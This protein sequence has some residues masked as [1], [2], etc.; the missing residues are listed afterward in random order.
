M[1]ER[2][3]LPEMTALFTDKARFQAF[4]EVEVAAA[5]ALGDFGVIPK[6]AAAAIARDARIDIARIH[7]LEKATKHDVVA[8]TR[9][10]SE[11]LGDHAKWLHYGLTST[12]VVDTALAMVLRQA[13][14]IIKK[15]A[16][17]YQQTLKTLALTHRQTPCVGRT[18]GIHAEVTS[19]GLKFARFYDAFTRQLARFDATVSAMSVGKVSGAVGTYAHASPD[20]E[21]HVCNQLGLTPA[22][23]SSQVLDRDRHADLLHSLAMMGTELERVALEI[24]H[25]QRTEINEVSERFA[26]GQKGSSAM[27]HKQNPIA[28]ENITGCARLMRG[29]ASMARE[30]IALWHERDISHSSVERVAL[31]D[32]FMV[33]DYMLDRFAGVL[34]TLVV[35]EKRMRDNIDITRGGIFTQRVLHAMI[36]AGMDRNKA[37][38]T[39]QKTAFDAHEQGMHL[40]EALHQNDMV[41]A[42]LSKESIDACFDVMWFLRHVD[43]IYDRVFTEGWR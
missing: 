1:I 9:A 26:T 41:L 33:L 39:V 22:T 27:P 32:A 2:Y 42:V 3:R 29:Y 16:S 23:T 8:F 6:H 25:L 13:S 18:H 37:Y 7:E 11:N 4:L 17:R 24:R 14:D 40:Q 34:E 21:K 20:V 28:S 38:D 31:P 5:Q 12:D 43:A 19:F 30:N 35:H 15:K 10:V 36:D